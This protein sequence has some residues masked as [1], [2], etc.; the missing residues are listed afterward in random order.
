M[1]LHY[2]FA[3][4]GTHIYKK[5]SGDKEQI[6]TEA[7]LSNPVG[8]GWVGP[9]TGAELN[10]MAAPTLERLNSPVKSPSGKYDPVALSAVARHWHP[11]TKYVGTYDAHWQKEIFP[12]LPE[13]FDDQFHQCA[14]EDQQIPYPKGGEEVVLLN[15]M[16]GR[17]RVR[18]KLPKLDNMQVRIL[19]KDYSVVTQNAVVDTLYFE[20]EE[21]RFSA[22]WR[23]SV[24]IQRRIQEFDTVAIGPIDI[25]WWQNKILGINGNGCA[26]CKSQ[27]EQT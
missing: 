15:M 12:F 17:E 11:R 4:G 1:P 16:I 26:G 25:H 21:E 22:V 3:F 9:K 20:P 6:L 5:G 19:R 24:P 13:D 23:V 2:G 8:T 10:D 27:K 14:P 7:L 18:F